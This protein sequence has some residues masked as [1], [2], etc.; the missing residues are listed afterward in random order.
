MNKIFFLFLLGSAWFIT[1]CKDKAPEA[2]AAPEEKTETQ[3]PVT[4]TTAEK[5]TLQEYVDL[6]A[7]SVFLT[8][9]FVKAN[10]NGYLQAVNTRPG[11]YVDKGKEL[12]TLKTKE[13]E[14]L[15]NTIT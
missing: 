1:A 4:I 6:N 11:D 3:T 14:S 2:A 13:A 9:S 10:A 5:G 12:F 8:K 7:T 15:G